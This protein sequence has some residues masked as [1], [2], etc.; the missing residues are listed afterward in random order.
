MN[1]IRQVDSN[2][3]G[4]S[5]EKQ[6]KTFL[7]YSRANKDFA[8]KLAKELKS[9]GFYIWLDQLDI[10]AGSRWDREVEKALEECEIFMIILTPAAINS[11][12]VLD[13]IGYAVDN[14]KHFLPVMLETCNVPLRLRRFQYVDFTTKSFDDGVE[15]AKDLLRNLIAQITTSRMDVPAESQTQMAQ[16]E[17]DRK[18][19]EDSER[20]ARQRNDEEFAAKA[21]AETE[22]KSKEESDR[23]AAQKAEREAKVEADRKA[24][25]KL[26]PVEAVPA[27]IATTTQKKPIS[28]G[29]VIGI[30]A[31]V[32]LI[33]AGIGYSIL[34]KNTTQPTEMPQPN[35]IPI[36]VSTPAL[37]PTAKVL[38]V[39]STMVGNDGMTLL[40]VPAGEFIMGSDEGDS[41]ERPAHKVYLDAYWIDQTEVTNVM[42]AECV[43]A[44]MCKEPTNLSSSTRLSYFK[45]SEYNN[46]PV[47]FVDWDMAKT[48]C[49][50]AERRL[51]T[52]AEWEKA[53][54]G[55]D[56]RKYPWG[57]ENPNGNLLNYNKNIGD[58]TEVG[59]YLM[60][61]S[62]YGS[63]DMS[64][65]IWEWVT[66]WYDKTYYHESQN[67]N[68]IGPAVGERRVLRG[69]SWFGDSFNARTTIRFY[70]FPDTSY[71]S[72]GFR[73]SRSQ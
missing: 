67:K 31:V 61:A 19:K 33:V 69:G 59:K 23:L 70:G 15:S 72:I 4:M 56:Q 14:G 6:R 21:R 58:T 55:T 2:G 40:Y 32:I 48:Y 38:D 7:S 68:P 42:Y 63:V 45:N 22:R 36:V 20:I 71:N 54:R 16:A 28:N 41:D 30:V 12:N 17:A 43:A 53:A 3:A 5:N 37:S 9:E 49:E 24:Q 27:E 25:A 47:I 39:G 44:G 10:P 46:F 8:L 34:S 60:G 50:W 1:G 65:N 57:N 73:C 52:E 51:P 35:K 29:P 11:E 62:S 66:D 18:A 13:E 26:K 64:G